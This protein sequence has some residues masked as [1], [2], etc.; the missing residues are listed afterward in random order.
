[1]IMP[2]QTVFKR[3]IFFS[4]GLLLLAVVGGTIGF[5]LIEHWSVLDALYMTVITLTTVGFGELHPLSPV[6]RMFT[7]A[8]IV[9][10]L[11]IV[12][13]ISSAVVNSLASGELRAR[14][15]TQRRQ[16][17]LKKL[18]NHNIVC[19]FGRMGQHVAAELR[20]QGKSL[21]IIDNNET[22]VDRAREIGYITILGDAANEE[23]L[24]YAG[25]HRARGLFAALD[26]DAG[27]V[28]TVLTARALSASLIIVARVNYD[29]TESKLRRAGADKVISPYVIGGRRMVHYVDQ[30]GVVDFLDVV[31]HSPDLELRMQEV[32]V[33]S[34]S[35]IAGQ[36]LQEVDLRARTGVNVL[37]VRCPGE[38]PT[39]TP[40]SDT[41]L[42]AGTHLIVLGTDTQLASLSKLIGNAQI[43]GSGGHNG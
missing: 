2:P 23:I 17:V 37:S 43:A 18:Q 24:R 8:L 38:A 35:P 15:I 39:T 3:R 41:R 9:G 14:F 27:N 31:M 28:F 36:S 19:G 40:G 34:G 13:Y 29:E 32:T 16:R 33:A 1:M 5:Q 22:V 20:A 26:S 25:I 7:L 30:P 10:G 12:G 6:G 42:Y 4:L 21:V 11:T